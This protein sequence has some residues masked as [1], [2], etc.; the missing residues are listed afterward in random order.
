MKT[1]SKIL[2]CGGIGGGAQMALSDV[3]IRLYGVVSGNADAAAEALA[4]VPSFLQSASLFGS[5]FLTYFILFINGLLA[6]A[7]SLCLR[8]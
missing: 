4:A 7:D 6:A 1:S 2:I 8:R 5:Y 3:G